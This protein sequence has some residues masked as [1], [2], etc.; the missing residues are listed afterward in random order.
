[1]AAS[2]SSLDVGFAFERA[3]LDLAA[4]VEHSSAD[5]EVAHDPSVGAK[6][7][8]GG[9]P[10]WELVDRLAAT[11]SLEGA[12]LGEPRAHR[13]GVDRLA[14]LRECEHRCVHERVLLAV[15]VLR[16]QTLLEHYRLERLHAGEQDSAEHAALGLQVVRGDVRDRRHGWHHPVSGRDRSTKSPDGGSTRR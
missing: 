11:G 8:G 1:L 16:A 6:V 15:E 10:A 7:A 2:A 9:H 5:G 12:V 14:P 3:L 4:G 13:Q